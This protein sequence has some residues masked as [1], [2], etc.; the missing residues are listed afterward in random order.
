MMASAE[1]VLS[2]GG[3]SSEDHGDDE[4]RSGDLGWVGVGPGHPGLAGGDFV[5]DS[6]VELVVFVLDGCVGRAP[7]VTVPARLAAK[8]ADISAVRLVAPPREIEIMHFSM[9][10]HPRLDDDRAQR[11]LRE[12]IRSVTATYRTEQPTERVE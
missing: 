6:G 5:H 4:R 2:A 8:H 3:E 11:W 1:A 10:W 12:I 7:G 9:C